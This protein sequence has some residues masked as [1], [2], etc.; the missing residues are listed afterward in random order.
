M[1]SLIDDLAFGL[2]TLAKA[3]GLAL[4]AVLSLGTPLVVA[5]RVRSQLFGVAPADPITFS[6]VIG[7]SVRWPRA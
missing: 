1:R 2:R 7:L 3:P 5:T 6:A 4:V